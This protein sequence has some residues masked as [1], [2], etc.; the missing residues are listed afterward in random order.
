MAKRKLTISISEY[1]DDIRNIVVP[2]LQ[3]GHNV[4]YKRYSNLPD[5]G[6]YSGE[7]DYPLTLLGH[8]NE[9]NFKTG[10]GL[11]DR[12]DGAT[13]AKT[14]LQKNLK[15]STFPFCLIAGCSGAADKVNGLYITIGK[16]LSIPT[17]ASSTPIKI[18]RTGGDISLQPQNGG[19]WRVYFPQS[20]ERYELHVRGRCDAIRTALDGQEFKCKLGV[21]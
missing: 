1:D 17:V 10:A 7:G 11:G 12:V 21:V 18:S 6:D 15:A 2:A 8:A 14:L 5:L 3:G 13:V 19:V 16:A 4:T 20:D 9:L